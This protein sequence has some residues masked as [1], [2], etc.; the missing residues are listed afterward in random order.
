MNRFEILGKLQVLQNGRPLDLGSRKQQIVLAM[1]ACHANSPVSVDLLAD[2]L[3]DNEPPRTARKNIQVYVSGLRTLLGL[4]RSDARVSL[5]PGGY[6]LQAG[7][8]EAD[9]L[10]FEEQVRTYRRRFLG[11]QSGTVARGLAD[12]LAIWRGPVLDGLREVAGIDAA[13][14]R[15]ERQ[16]LGAFEDWAEAEVAVGGAPGAVERITEVADQHPFRERLRMI[17]MSALCQ[18]GRRTE[19]LAVYDG[20]RQSLAQE[21]GL[22]PSEAVTAFYQSLLRERAPAVVSG[23]FHQGSRAIG[24]ALPRQVPDLTGR[25]ACAGMLTSAVTVGHERIAVVTG[26]VGAG[27]TTL[28]VHAAYQLADEFPDGQFFVRVRGEDGALRPAADVFA[29]LL[30]AV[31]LPELAAGGDAPTRWQRWLTQHRALIVLDDARS[32]SEARPFLPRMGESVAIVTARPQLTGLDPAYRLWVP[33]FTMDEA[34]EFLGKVIGTARV[35]AD[36]DSAARIAASA[37]LLPLGLRL[38]AARLALLRHVPLR[39]YAARLADPPVLLDELSAGDVTIRGCLA[40]AI[41]DLPEQARWSF[42]R[43][44]LLDRLFTVSEA[45]QALGTDD[46]SAG[47]VLETMLEASLIMVPDAETVAHAVVYEIP[48]LAHLYARELSPA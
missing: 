48:V 42:P 34:L 10:Q 11:E 17:Q 45:A 22:G 21:L 3:W 25:Q 26:P 41:A 36:R 47:R 28:A 43:L 44:G 12:A 27:K 46:E 30:W 1:L 38:I 16:F 24:S 19:A 40:D 39:E 2:A 4:N 35:A 33:S 15:L 31:G 9:W 32:E 7:P 37:G 29:G 20:L 8:A 14:Q 13:V 5:Q 18:V 23:G 6:V